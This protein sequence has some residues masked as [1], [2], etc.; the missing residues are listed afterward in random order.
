MTDLRNVLESTTQSDSADP[1]SVY[2]TRLRQVLDQ[3]APL[4][5]RTVTGRTSAPWM[6]MEVKQAK[7]ER[8]IA[9]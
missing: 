5:T 2:N 1:L 3:H 8:R 4:V 6:T 9:E 7:V